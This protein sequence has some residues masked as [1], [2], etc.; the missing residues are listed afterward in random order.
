MFVSFFPRPKAFFISLVLW[1]A[2]VTASWYLGGRDLGAVAGF[3]MAEGVNPPLIGLGYFITDPFLWFYVYYAAA[4]ALFAA[5][6]QAIAPHP[7]WRWS[8]LGS[9]VILFVTYFQVQVS[10]AIN[11]WVGP[12]WDLVQAAVSGSRQV[13]VEEFYGQLFIFASIAL[14][15]ITVAV[16]NLF[17]VSHWIFRWRTAMNDYYLSHWPKLRS[18]EGASQRVQEDTMRFSRLVESL[19]VNFVD[20]I[21]TLIDSCRC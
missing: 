17:F 16:M 8:I 13:S 9:A 5:A 2:L 18:V 3:D 11:T 20:S 10:V 1:A 19:G 15:A 21:M 14:V 12:F 4:V 6:W 7:W